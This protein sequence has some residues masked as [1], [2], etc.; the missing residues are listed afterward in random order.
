VAAKKSLA[1]SVAEEM[2]C[3]LLSSKVSECLAV[4]SEQRSTIQLSMIRNG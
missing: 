3:E 2:R 1:Y 4:D